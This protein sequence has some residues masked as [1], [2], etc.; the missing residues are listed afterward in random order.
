MSRLAGVAREQGLKAASRTMNSVAP[1]RCARAFR[2]ATQPGRQRRGLDRA[3]ARR[4]ASAGAGGRSAGRAARGAPRAGAPV[5]ELALQHGAAEPV[6]LPDGEV[7]VLDGS[8]GRATGGVALHE[9]GVERRQL[10]HEDAHRPAVGDDVVHGEEQD[11]LRL[12]QPQQGGAQQ[13][14]AREVER[15]RA[16]SRRQRQA[17]RLALGGGERPEVDHWAGPGAP[18]RRDDLH[19]LA[20]HRRRTWCAATSW[21]SHDLGERS[22][23]GRASSAPRSRKPTGML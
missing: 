21:R 22:R 8:G 16:S 5:G 19:R 10:A 1:S 4:S 2:A 20:V 13:R 12:V 14:P 18:W 11:V 7:G 3:A 15:R 23:R 6:A 9:R 17:P